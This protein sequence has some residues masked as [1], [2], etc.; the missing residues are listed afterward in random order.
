MKVKFHCS[1]RDFQSK[2]SS[3]IE[4]FSD[5]TTKEELEEMAEEFFWNEKEPD[6]WYEIIE[7]N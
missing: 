5:D 3:D 7:D 6:W 2:A 4:E 1:T